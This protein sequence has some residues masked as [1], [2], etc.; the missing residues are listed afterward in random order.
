MPQKSADRKKPEAQ[1]SRERR[2]KARADGT[3]AD[4]MAA[5]R[6][7]KA[8][9]AAERHARAIQKMAAVRRPKTYPVP[10]DDLSLAFFNMRKFDDDAPESPAT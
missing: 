10:S 4:I 6:D 5:A 9:K 3:W 7:A 1:R 8:K 2:A